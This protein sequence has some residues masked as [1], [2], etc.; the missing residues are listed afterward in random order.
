MAGKW[1]NFEELEE[2]LSV[3][4]L[5]LILKTINKRDYEQRQFEAAIQGIDIEKSGRSNIPMEGGEVDLN[6]L[7]ERKQN[8][9]A[10]QQLIERAE[11]GFVADDAAEIMALPGIEYG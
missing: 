2:S 3:D 6:A 5:M 9:L 10:Q 4:E 11:G 7:V 1:K 8:E